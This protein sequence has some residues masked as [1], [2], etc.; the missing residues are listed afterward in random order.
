MAGA[1]EPAAENSR[2]NPFIYFRGTA[3]AAM[4]F[5]RDVFGGRLAISR[6]AEF[7]PAD[8]PDADKVMH[9]Q[10]ETS[11]GF[12]LMA[13]DTPQG[14]EITPGTTMCISVS[15]TNPAELH[16]YWERLSEG[17]IVTVPMDRQAWG[18]EFG[19][20]VDRFGISWMINIERPR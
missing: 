12:T 18:D 10:L 11:K 16:G 7:G 20:C 2:L 13:S 3:R 9:A 15:G 14:M 8:S 17:G 6:F 19:A 1:T 5:Y 4:E